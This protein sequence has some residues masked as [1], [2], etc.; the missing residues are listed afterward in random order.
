MKRIAIALLLLMLPMLIFAQSVSETKTESTE[1]RIFTDS[2]GR[3]IEIPT[4]ISRVA[5]SGNVA[6]LAIYAVAPEKMVGW[7]SRLSDSAM[8]TFLPEVANLPVFGA[9][10]GKKANLNKEALIAADPEVVIDVGEIKGSKEAMAKQLDELSENIGL[11]VIFVEGYLENADEMF[12]ALG[13][14]L[15][16]KE[17]ASKLATFSKDALEM[18][19]NNKDKIDTTIYYSSAPDGLKAVETGSF[20]GEVIEF[21]GC[22]NVVP[23]TF[24]N[25]NGSTSLEQIYLWDPDVILLSSKDAYNIATTDKAWAE[26]RAVQNGN[27]YMMPIVPYPF[28]DTPPA[29]NRMIGIYWLGNLLNPDAYDLDINEKVKEYYSLFYHKDLTDSELDSILNP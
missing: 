1:T 24:T 25:S 8:E 12:L 26:L 5:P 13:D 16:A 22:E 29:T 10:Y 2:L 7:S 14:I 6:Q 3:E 28:L 17:Q 19:R 11:P 27:V 4:T 20:H 18:A 21:V 15:N 23:S 9:F